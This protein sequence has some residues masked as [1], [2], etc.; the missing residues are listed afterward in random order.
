MKTQGD[1]KWFG[2]ED[3]KKYFRKGQVPAENHF[4]FLI[5]SM[6][7]KQDDGF[8]K[9]K[10]D[11]LVIAATDNSSRFMS[12]YKNVNDI[13][14]FFS[15]ERDGQ[16]VEN[17]KLNPVYE[18]DKMANAN[19]FYFDV[20]GR[21]GIGKASELPYKFEVDGFAAMQGRVG[22]YK[23]GQVAADGKW[24]TIL[25]GLDNCSA[26]EIVA[27][28]GKKGSGKFAIMHAVAMSA[29]GGTR[30]RIRSTSAYYGFF[31]N[32]LKLRWKGTTHNYSLQIKTGNN[33]GADVDI[34]YKITRL[35]DDEAFMPNEYFNSWKNDVAD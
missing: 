11:G 33:Y 21:L 5:D 16:D 9:D 4:S 34:F 8:L 24:Q 10:E 15:L 32:K 20:E 30:G 14:P 19:S 2:R 26:F 18:D 7:N 29:F 12:F 3:L 28:T 35:W 22:T 23:S 13:N 31:W 27:R 17:L 6:I 1:N 25:E